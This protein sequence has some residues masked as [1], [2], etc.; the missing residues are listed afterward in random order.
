M[1]VLFHANINLFC[2]LFDDR[3][4]IISILFISEIFGWI[5]FLG[6]HSKQLIERFQFL[7]RIF[8]K[9]CYNSY[10][11]IIWSYTYGIAT[12]VSFINTANQPMINWRLEG[13]FIFLSIK[14]LPT[15][16]SFCI[17]VAIKNLRKA[18]D[19][20]FRIFGL[21]SFHSNGAILRR[22]RRILLVINS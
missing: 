14:N 16:K 1:S 17:I 15:K 10:P 11:Y 6:A 20:T 7:A 19:Y 13:F 21:G 2:N 3:R 9:C 8:R 12:T 18:V 4:P 5:I 22:I